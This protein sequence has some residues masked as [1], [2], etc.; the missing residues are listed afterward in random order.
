MIP[1]ALAGTEVADSEA[2]ELLGT[3]DMCTRKAEM[4]RLADAFRPLPGGLGTLDELL[5]VWTTRT[6]GLRCQAGRGARP[7][8][9]SLLRSASSPRQLRS[10]GFRPAG[11]P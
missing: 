2:D 11:C 7:G 10:A 9:G 6:L 1:E 8:G 4:V 3:V 5:E